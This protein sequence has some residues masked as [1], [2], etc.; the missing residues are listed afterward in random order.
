MKQRTIKFRYRL[1]EIKTDKMFPI[2]VKD[3]SEIE[4]GIIK[5]I[6]NR[7]MEI[8]S[9]D[10]YTN[11]KDKNGVEIY[12]SDIINREQP[13]EVVFFRG[14]FHTHGFSKKGKE[15]WQPLDTWIDENSDKLFKYEI[16]GN[17]YENP[18]LL[19]PQPKAGE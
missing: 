2:F 10:Q 8:L 16:I 13:Y 6:C 7:E 9:R 3:I 1:R 15:F 18:E 12:S 19:T 5:N 11:L 4:E 17:I 14:G